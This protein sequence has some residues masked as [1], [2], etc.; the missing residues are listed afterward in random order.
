MNSLWIHYYQGSE[1]K[2][3]IVNFNLFKLLNLIIFRNDK[4]KKIKEPI[5]YPYPLA[6]INGILIIQM[7]ITRHEISKKIRFFLLIFCILKLINFTN[8]INIKNN[9]KMLLKKGL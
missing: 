5:K 8:K 9:I 1:I 4:N 6:L 2:I 7:S 3:I